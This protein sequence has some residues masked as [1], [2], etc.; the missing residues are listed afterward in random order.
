MK[1]H[2]YIF[3][4][5]LSAPESNSGGRLQSLWA[6]VWKERV[7]FTWRT[8]ASDWEPD[9]WCA[10]FPLIL[11]YRLYDLPAR[12]ATKW[13]FCFVFRVKNDLKDTEE[14]SVKS[15]ETKGNLKMNFMLRRSC[16]KTESSWTAKLKLKLKGS[17]GWMVLRCILTQWFTIWVFLKN[18]RAQIFITQVC[19]WVE[20]HWFIPVTQQLLTASCWGFCLLVFCAG[21][22]SSGCIWF[23]SHWWSLFGLIYHWKSKERIKP[24]ISYRL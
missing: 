14:K 13:T 8:E 12:A 15:W 16:G 5:S 9:T 11:C 1:E 21:G 19:V 10:A 3:Q 17:C 2:Y 18:S 24:L 7:S 20:G 23:K 22:V 6:Q 4:T